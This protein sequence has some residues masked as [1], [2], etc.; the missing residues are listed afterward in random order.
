MGEDHA[1]LGSEEV[2]GRIFDLHTIRG[3]HMLDI[4]LGSDGE[5]LLYPR[6]R[7]TNSGR[8]SLIATELLDELQRI[9]VELNSLTESECDSE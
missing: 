9:E 3:D 5:M 8:A 7:V 4:G 2:L 6:P 1:I